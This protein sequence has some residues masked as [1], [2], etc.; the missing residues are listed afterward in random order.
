MAP[1]VKVDKDLNIYAKLLTS[2]LLLN[3]E[4]DKQPWKRYSSLP[5]NAFSGLVS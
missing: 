3:L 1:L 2:C 4:N 5:T